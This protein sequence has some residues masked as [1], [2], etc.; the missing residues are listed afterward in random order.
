MAAG[1]AGEEAASSSRTLL[2]LPQKIPALVLRPSP[3]RLL[4]PKPLSPLE[5]VVGPH[6][7]IH[8]APS[9]FLLTPISLPHDQPA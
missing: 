7:T 8:P 6:T 3:V 1:T 9:C 4:A 5:E 2:H